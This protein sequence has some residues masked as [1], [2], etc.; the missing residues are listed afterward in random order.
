MFEGLLRPCISATFRR[1]TLLSRRNPCLQQGE[2]SI[3]LERKPR[4]K[5]TFSSVSISN[6]PY[7]VILRQDQ[8]PYTGRLPMFRGQ[9]MWVHTSMPA[10]LNATRLIMLAV[11]RAIIDSDSL[12]FD[13]ARDLPQSTL[14]SKIS[15]ASDNTSYHSQRSGGDSTKPNHRTRPRCI[16]IG[17]TLNT[18]CDVATPWTE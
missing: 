7:S 10:I 14:S 13:D 11:S 6:T 15:I 2:M 17:A 5:T 1:H 9:R 12:L 16:T 18:T 3:S 4:F 8:Q